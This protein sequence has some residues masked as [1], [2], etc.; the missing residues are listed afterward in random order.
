MEKQHKDNVPVIGSGPEAGLGVGTL[1]QTCCGSIRLICP[2]QTPY[3]QSAGVRVGALLKISP[4][5]SPLNM[6]NGDPKRMRSVS[7]VHDTTTSSPGYIWP[8]VPE[9]TKVVR[10]TNKVGRST[11]ISMLS[12]EMRMFA[13]MPGGNCAAES[14]KCGN[15]QVGS[16]CPSSMRRPGLVTSKGVPLRLPLNE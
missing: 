11:L 13:A 2:S 4:V 12:S 5:V 16:G 1:S 3:R 9:T 7:G 6:H 10:A 15:S 14:F 8:G